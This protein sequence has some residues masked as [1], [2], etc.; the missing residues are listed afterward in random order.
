MIYL[1]DRHITRIGTPWPELMHLVR[2]VLRLQGTAE[3][4]QPLKPYLRYRDPRNRIIAMPAFVGG[5]V[6]ASGIKWIASFPGNLER[7]LPRAHNTLI[8]NDTHTGEPIAFL[9]SGKLSAIRTA[10]V[11]G[12]ML[13]AYLESR[14]GSAEPS[15]GLR[16][17]IVGMGPIGRMHLAML[18]SAYG[19]RIA[20]L[21]A[22][23]VRGIAAASLPKEL[24]R[25]VR[26]CSSWQEV[27][28]RSDVFLTCTT[29]PER[30]IDRPPR[31]GMLLLNVS[32]RD[33]R[34]ESVDRLSAVVVDDWLEVCRENTDIEMLHRSCGLEEADVL[35]LRQ[36]IWDNA[37]AAI[38]PEEPIFFNPMGMAAFDIAVAASYVR[39]A[40]RLGIGSRLP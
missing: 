4:V 32:L 12:A 19:D 5:E 30:Y 33:Y 25:R 28:E 11:S 40:I 24:R 16:I 26:V 27:Y 6:E 38:P 18:H 35:T 13:G 3:L 9:R 21:R 23:D 37:L 34:P 2:N 17:G 39:Q 20:E 7:G 31:P 10:A 22:F 8:L 15:A 29:S 1:N 14:P 36:A